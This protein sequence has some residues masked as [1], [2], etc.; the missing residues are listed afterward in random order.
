MR[1]MLY[2][3]VPVLV[4]IAVA[5]VWV[6]RNMAR[7]A[8]DDV[9]VARTGTAVVDVPVDVPADVP[10]TTYAISPNMD[11][12]LAF[13]GY[14]GILGQMEG[15]FANFTGEISIA[16]DD[17]AT[18]KVNVVIDMP[19]LFS[20]DKGLTKKL[21]D[22]DFFDVDTYPTSTFTSTSIEKAADGYT[23]TGNLDLHGVVK[24]VSFP[25]QMAMEGEDVKANAEFTIDRTQWN[26]VY[27]N[28]GGSTISKECL[29]RFIILAERAEVAAANEA[30][31]EAAATGAM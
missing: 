3:L 31:A 5:G 30:P 2:L 4:L 25:V 7:T 9:E 24:S 26:I 1:K 11:S 21:V 28:W 14:G 18:A 13:I 12:E 16:G 17:L 10:L 23:V 27:D 6:S 15:G 19:T 20:E 22:P 8:P 29:V